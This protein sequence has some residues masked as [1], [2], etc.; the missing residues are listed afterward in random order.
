MPYS[1][2]VLVLTPSI[3]GHYFGELVA[4]LSREVADVGGVSCSFKRWK[5]AYAVSR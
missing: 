1:V 4:G 5:A 2:T 3:G